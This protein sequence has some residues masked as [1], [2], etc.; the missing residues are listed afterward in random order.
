MLLSHHQNAGQ[1]YDMKI[2]NRSFENV[3]QFKYLGVALTKQNLIQEEI[4]RRLNLGNACSHSILNLSSSRVLSKNL[5]IRICKTI[6]LSLDLY[7]CETWSLILREEQRVRVFENRVLRR[8]FG[9]K[10]DDVIGG[11]RKLHKEELHNL[12]SSPR[13][14]RMIILGG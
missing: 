9:S 4:K 2:V 10:R 1:N 12:Y 6:I 3:A 11:W 13:I 14:V 7:E 8:I 5:K